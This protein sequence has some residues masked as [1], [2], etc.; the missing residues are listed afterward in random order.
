MNKLIVCIMGQDCK[1]FAELCLE[2]VKDADAIVFCDGGS[3]PEFMSWLQ[4]RA[5]DLENMSIIQR[6]F[7]QHDPGNNGKQRNFYLAFLNEQYPDWW[8]LCLDADEVISSMDK[9]KEFIAIQDT[10]A[11]K[12]ALWSVHMRH[13]IYNFGQEDAIVDKHFVGNRLFKIAPDL[14]YPEGEHI[15]LHSKTPRMQARTEDA[16]TIW[17]LAYCSQMFNVRSRYRKNIKHSEVH[18]K[19]YLDKWR[20]AH[21]FGLY[22]TKDVNPKDLPS[23]LLKGMEVDP[24]SIYFKGRDLEIKHFIDAGNWRDHFQL[25]KEDFVMEWGCG[26]GVRVYALMVAGV[27]AQGIEISEYACQHSLVPNNVLQGSITEEHHIPVPPYKL[28]IAYDLLEHVPYEKLS[29][30]IDNLIKGSKQYI[31][32]SVPVIGDPNLERDPTHIIR[33]TKDWWRKQFTDKGC[34]ELTVP[35]HFLYRDQQMIFEAPRVIV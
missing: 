29:L 9:L 28:V 16:G 33:E 6:Q 1:D 2:S 25:G 19:E 15:V 24:D 34:K 32:V 13:F 20:D 3:K 10:L 11:G 21:Y 35:Q 4:E 22:P 8:C 5:H 7:D 14:F 31:L 30:A 12:D 27:H 23:C 17:H 26:L 18:S